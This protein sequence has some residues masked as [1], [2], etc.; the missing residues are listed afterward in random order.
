MRRAWSRERLPAWTSVSMAICLPGRPS[1]ANRAAT[2]LV[3]VEPAVITTNCTTAMI[4]NTTA[5][6]TRLLAATNAPNASTTWPAAPAPSTAARAR[7]SRVVAMLSTSR[8]RVAPRR[9][10]G[11]MLISSGVRAASAPSSASTETVRL[12]ASRKSTT[13]GGT[14]ASTTSRAR[15]MAAGIA[16]SRIVAETG[17][18][19]AAAVPGER[20]MGVEHQTEMGIVREPSC[21]GGTVAEPPATVQTARRA[22]ERL[23]SHGDSAKNRAARAAGQHQEPIADAFRPLW[24]RLR[25]SRQLVRRG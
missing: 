15:R 14:G 11:K 8:T 10:V 2:S 6:T 16:R 24:T 3:R 9:N 13:T 23:Q 19:M 17:R 5:P 21:E 18:R 25:L 4:A 20:D 1:R 7:I 22:G 12:A